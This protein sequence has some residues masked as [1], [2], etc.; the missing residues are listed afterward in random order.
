MMMMMTTGISVVVSAAELDR[1][2]LFRDHYW[3]SRGCRS[4]ERR[5]GE[6][7]SDSQCGTGEQQYV[8][9]DLISLD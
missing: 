3:L 8:F 7:D 2:A 9:H 5:T 6:K 1:Y 4:G